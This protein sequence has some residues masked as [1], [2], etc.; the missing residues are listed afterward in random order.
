MKCVKLSEISFLFLKKTILQNNKE[1]KGPPFIFQNINYK[2]RN[3]N[4]INIAHKCIKGG[5][6]KSD[7]LIN[8]AATVLL[9]YQ[10]QQER[11]GGGKD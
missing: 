11:E 6:R 7:R 5:E 2:Q 4:V 1:G 8:I 9:I 3:I 10:W